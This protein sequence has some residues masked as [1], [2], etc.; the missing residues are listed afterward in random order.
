MRP[1]TS[2]DDAVAGGGEAGVVGDDQEGGAEVAVNA[3]HQGEDLVGRR[4][5]EVAGGLVGEHQRRLARQRAGDR[6]ALLHAARQLG[7]LAQAIARPTARSSASASLHIARVGVTGRSRISA[8][9]TTFSSAVKAGSRWW[10]WNTKP[11]V[12]ARS[13]VRARRRGRWCRPASGSS[14]G[15]RPLEQADDVEQRALARARRPDQRG[16]RR[17]CR[18]ATRRAAPRPRWHRGCSSCARR[19]A[20]RR[21]QA[22]RIACAGSR[23]A[24]RRAGHRGQHAATP[25]RWPTTSAPARGRADGNSG[26]AVGSVASDEG[27]RRP[28]SPAPAARQQ[29]AGAPTTPPCMRKTSRICAAWRRSRAGCRSRALLHH[30]HDQH[31][32]DA[33]HHD[34]HHHAADQPVLTDCALSA[35]TSCAL[36][37]CQLSTL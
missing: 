26:S 2:L 9:S 11:S 30:R 25:W 24:A 13:A 16:T 5:V 28:I 6:H 17:G 3:A 4:G 10:N 12:R 20:E 15:G 33:E 31:A 21:A 19:R 18:S 8:G 1:S 14:A 36:V 37:S 35:E 34:H 23:R 7:A 22:L 32:G 27:W 29:R